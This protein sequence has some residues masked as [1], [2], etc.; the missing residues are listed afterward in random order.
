MS[1]FQLLST[2]GY[3]LRARFKLNGKEYAAMDDFTAFPP[4]KVDWSATEF[5]I[6]RVTAQPWDS[7]FRGNP[8][9]RKELVSRGHWSYDGYGEIISIRPVV[10]DFGDFRF[11]V[12]D[13][14]SDER[15][16]GEFIHVIIDRLELAF[17]TR[18]SSG[19]GAAP[20]GGPPVHCGNSGASG[21]PPSVS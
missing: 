5:S 3:G 18:N 1:E 6:L 14:T 20:N 15:C 4:E 13:F 2:E 16:I 8:E 9:R 21:G 11:D 17:H 12:G 19:R 7:M 10:V